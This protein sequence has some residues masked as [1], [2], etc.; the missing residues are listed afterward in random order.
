MA[1]IGSYTVTVFDPEMGTLQP[2]MQ[3][4][5]V[6][7]SAAGVDDVGVVAGGWSNRPQAVRTVT[8]VATSS[9]AATLWNNYR[10]LSGTVVSVLDQFGFT[11]PNVTVFRVGPARIADVGYGGLYRLEVQWVL[12]PQTTRPVA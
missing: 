4:T 12:L 5:A 7:E 8:Q 10:A 6:L 3:K 9:A 11:W 1:R 2:A